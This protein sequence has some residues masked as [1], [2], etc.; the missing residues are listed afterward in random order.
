MKKTDYVSAAELAEW[1]E[2]NKPKACPI[3]GHSSFTPVVD[4]DHKTGRIRAVI[5]LEGNALIGKIENFY[6]SR[7]VNARYDLPE[8]L[9][10]I[11]LYLESGQGPLHPVGVRQVTKR[12]NRSSKADQQAM[13]ELEG[14]SPEEISKCKN[15]K[16]RTA[17]YR[18]TIVK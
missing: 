15:A 1:R 18:R 5:S 3:L 14:V 12:F 7:C 4:H 16:E 2:A 17:L 10:C 8:V 6:R 9:R 11:A 13:L